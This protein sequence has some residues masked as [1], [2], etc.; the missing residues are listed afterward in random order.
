MNHHEHEHHEHEH[1]DHECCG[2]WC[3]EET[4]SRALKAWI[5]L[6]RLFLW[7]AFVCSL[8]TLLLLPRLV[9]KYI[10]AEQALKAWWVENY[11]RLNKE[12][13]E[14]PEYKE[15]MKSEVE[16]FIQQSKMQMEMMKQQEQQP[17]TDDAAMMPSGEEQAAPAQDATAPTAQPAQ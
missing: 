9:K 13:Y 1:H 11:M 16:N 15:R 12:I 5:I 6:Q 2:G 7:G 4:S 10:V 17:Q 3:C 8:L 14:S